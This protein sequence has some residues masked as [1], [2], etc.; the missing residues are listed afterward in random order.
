MAKDFFLVYVNS[1]D[2][3]FR[4]NEKV[5]VGLLSGYISEQKW[6]YGSFVL[7]GTRY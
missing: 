3:Y 2:L 7:N 1:L 4:V 6:F 5:N